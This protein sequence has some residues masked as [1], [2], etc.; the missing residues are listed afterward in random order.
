MERADR[1]PIESAD[2]RVEVLGQGP[3]EA[4]EEDVEA[5]GRQAP[6]LLGGDQRLARPR[7]AEDHRSALAPQHVVSQLAPGSA[8]QLC[9]QFERE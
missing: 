9:G 5:L 4:G 1:D 6:R 7:H 8:T 3:V 2:G